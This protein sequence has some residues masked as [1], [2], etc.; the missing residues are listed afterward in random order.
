MGSLKK[1]VGAHAAVGC[2]GVYGPDWVVSCY[3]KLRRAFIHIRVPVW[4]TL[5]N[6]TKTT[7]LTEDGERR[8]QKF[9]SHRLRRQHT[10]TIGY[11]FIPSTVSQKANG[12]RE[13]RMAYVITLAGWVTLQTV[14]R[15]TK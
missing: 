14:K 10:D 15:L 7:F 2:G 12:K 1:L 11:S 8:R 4:A 3:D 6:A 5:Q 13:T 9:Q